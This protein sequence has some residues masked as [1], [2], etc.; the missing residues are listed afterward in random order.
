MSPLALMTPLAFM[1]V[2]GFVIFR[3]SD[4]K[5]VKMGLG[6]VTSSLFRASPKPT[7]LRLVGGHSDGRSRD[8]RPQ[9][10]TTTYEMAINLTFI[11]FI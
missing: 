3:C 5:S 7:R 6:S 10:F 2:L 11:N 9:G 1:F 4:S 8:G